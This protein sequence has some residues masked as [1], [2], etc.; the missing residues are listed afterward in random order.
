MGSVRPAERFAALLDAEQHVGALERAA[1]SALARGDLSEAFRLVDRRCRIFPVAQARHYTLRAE[2]AHRSG[3]EAAALEDL[4]TALELAPDDL[5]AN[6]R[7]MQWGDEERRQA[8]ARRLIELD[9]DMAMLGEAVTKLRAGGET[10][11]G[12][13]RRIGDNISGWVVWQAHGKI[14]LEIRSD[15]ATV[16]HSIGSDPQHALASRAEHA[17]SFSVPLPDASTRRVVS[18][19][20]NQRVIARTAFPA[21]LGAT[22][23]R[24]IPRDAVDKVGAASKVTVI[25]AVYDDLDATTRCLES[26]TAAIDG[27]DD[28]RVV[29]VDDATPDERIA[30]LLDATAAN[31]R[32]RLLRNSN[33]L[34][35]IGAVNRALQTV[36]SGDVIL[37]NSDTVV[38]NGFVRRLS[39][40]AYAAPDIGTVTPLSNNGEATS[41]P[42]PFTANPLLAAE[43]AARIDAIAERVNAGR[44]VD[45]PDGI[46]FCLY[47]TRACL[48]VVGGLSD[49]YHRGYLEDVDLCLRA[50]Q[51]GFRNV[52]APAIYVGHAGSASFKTEKRALV[53]L[54]LARLRQRFPNYREESA[55]FKAQDPLRVCRAAI[56]RQ[57]MASRQGATLVFSG[58]GVVSEVAASFARELDE[59][60][61]LVTFRRSGT[62]LT[63]RDAGNGFP[64]SLEFQLPLEAAQLEET[65]AALSPSRVVIADPARVPLALA[66]ELTRQGVRV[67]VF[68]ADGGL[69]CRRGGLD[70]RG[71]PCL[72][73][74]HG[75]ACDCGGGI[76]ESWLKHLTSESRIIA[77]DATAETMLRRRLPTNLARRVQLSRVDAFQNVQRPK[78]I[79]RHGDTFGFLVVGEEP[80]DFTLMSHLLRAMR[81]ERPRMKL[82]VLGETL[83]DLTLMALGNTVVT[84]PITANELG[85]F[86]ARHGLGWLAIVRRTPLFGHPLIATTFRDVDIPLA[87][88]DWSFG[89]IAASQFDLAISP[90]RDNDA[91]SADL[92]TWS[93]R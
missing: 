46:G 30:K 16:S 12:V 45:M 3:L 9:S 55:A 65:I 66:R 44:L 57:L 42:V 89:R 26:L 25:V 31:P 59:P 6:R 21:P 27:D 11:L 93:A 79:S 62:R 23:V 61:L 74:V 60:A 29:L 71:Q 19:A 56:E 81:K 76:A 34:G 4:D 49:H 38:P 82:T 88:F 86:A 2:I 52:C 40:T 72:K 77:P 73:L 75:T 18:L 13:I 37:L 1:I 48:D 63:V 5:A 24:T 47:I 22:R 64:Q 36:P 41:F 54:N 58:P 50:R 14:D 87:F 69:W 51:N 85:N 20:L 7:M 68:T 91:V 83:N 43:D 90:S 15:V 35:F 28:V 84:G 70:D 33:N 78:G 67:D 8:A 53:V 39:A 92:L 80:A 17:A 10:A 32:V